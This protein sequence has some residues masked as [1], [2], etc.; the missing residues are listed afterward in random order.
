[1]IR[2]ELPKP[3]EI[4]RVLIVVLALAA[5]SGWGSFILVGRSSAQVESELRGRMA[6][7][8]D[9][10]TQL[11][12]ERSQ[13]QAT[14]G[15]WEQMRAQLPALTEE[16]RELTQARDQ[17]QAE[18]VVARM[19]MRDAVGRPGQDPDDASAAGTGQAKSRD[20]KEVVIAAAQRTLVKLGH[21]KLTA[22]GTMGP[23]T[24]RAIEAFQKDKG[25][26]VT[27]ELDA[28]TL[29]KLTSAMNVAAR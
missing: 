2:R 13:A 14:V 18:L 7:L 21:G 19:S 16:V 27:S 23:G 1:M 11:L 3:S 4:H 29:R 25:L 22:D 10:H 17:T 15:N 28:P 6:S 9:S 8:Q 5:V 12:S 20:A 26:T 24:R